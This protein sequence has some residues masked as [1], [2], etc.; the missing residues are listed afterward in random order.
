MKSP[1]KRAFR[2][3]TILFQGGKT[4]FECCAKLI[5]A[6]LAE[7]REHILL[8]RFHTG[9]I[10]GIDAENV[11]GNRTSLFKEVYEITEIK[12]TARGERDGKVRNVAVRMREDGAVVSLLVDEVEALTCEEVKTVTVF[13]VGR[14]LDAF[15]DVDVDNGF[16]HQARAFLNELTERVEVCGIYGAGGIQTLAVL[17]FGF[18]EELFP[19]FAGQG[20]SGVVYGKDLDALT[21]SVENVANCRIFQ[22]AVC[23]NVAVSKIVKRLCRACEHFFYVNAG[24]G[25][26]KKTYGRKNGKSAA[27]VV[28]NDE[29]FIAVCIR[30]L[31]ECAACLVRGCEDAFCRAFLA[32]F[33]N[34][35]ITEYTESDSGLGCRTGFGNDVY[36]N[37]AVLADVKDI[38][39]MR[40]ADVLTDEINVGCVL[41]FVVVIVAVDKFDRRTCAEIRT[42][43]TNDDENVTK[44]T[45]LRA[46]SGY[47]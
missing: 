30:L 28:C 26:G 10:K 27:D 3:I 17:T 13:C 1:R 20:E 37:V 6:G 47:P 33:F 39:K 40:G 11:T 23:E 22:T 44:V 5:V 45:D 14:D 16:K 18:A 34:E 12:R 46:S 8:V 42:A 32:V 15:F 35:K 31:A 7:K 25:D 36:A 2:D 21:A 4:V 41:L 24:N 9:L 29:A 38:L 19:P 43:D